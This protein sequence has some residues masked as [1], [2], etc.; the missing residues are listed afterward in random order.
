LKTIKNKAGLCA[1]AL[2]IA[3]RIHGFR[4]SQEEVANK[5]RICSATISKRLSEFSQ[6]VASQMTPV[7][8]IISLKAQRKNLKGQ[9]NPLKKKW[10]L[11]PSPMEENLKRKKRKWKRKKRKKK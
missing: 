5:V 1:S 3:A 11:P 4:R 10:I 8:F 2:I 9:E 7:C 6:T